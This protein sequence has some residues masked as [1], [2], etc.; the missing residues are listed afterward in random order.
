MIAA[1]AIAAAHSV[2][3]STQPL[4]LTDGRTFAVLNFDRH[5]SIVLKTNGQRLVEHYFWVRYWASSRNRDSMFQEARAL[6]PA[7][8]GVADSLGYTLMELS[9]SQ[10]LL[11]RLL[12][13]GAV[14]LHIRFTRD[15]TGTWHE[16][17]K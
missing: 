14:S 12:P 16:V 3:W 8:Y 7:L 13:L 1:I 5:T 9:P 10:P 6:A 15:T 17:A 4:T 11:F 2:G